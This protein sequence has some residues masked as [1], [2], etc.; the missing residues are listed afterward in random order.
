MRVG[1]RKGTRPRRTIVKLGRSGQRGSREGDGAE[2]MLHRRRVPAA[3]QRHG[4]FGVGEFGSAP[5]S[6]VRGS[7]DD[8]AS[9]RTESPFAIHARGAPR[10]IFI[11][12]LPEAVPVS[13]RASPSIM[14]RRIESLVIEGARAFHHH[15]RLVHRAVHRRTKPAGARAASVYYRGTKLPDA[16]AESPDAVAGFAA[17][18]LLA[19]ERGEGR[20][21]R[22]VGSEDRITRLG[23][24]R[25]GRGSAVD[26][27]LTADV[28]GVGRR[29]EDAIFGGRKRRR[30]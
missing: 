18:C 8:D 10:G 25:I 29:P 4:G 16:P 3:K 28:I 22:R 30:L 2:A 7:A 26:P 14:Y 1:L 5:E 12:E 15:H 24:G 20:S 11:I 6:V 21:G 13:A 9:L 17:D 19:T 27:L 23:R